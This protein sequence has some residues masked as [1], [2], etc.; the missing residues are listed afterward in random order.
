MQRQYV[1]SSIPIPTLWWI[2]CSVLSVVFQNV[3]W[4]KACYFREQDASSV[5][6]MFIYCHGISENMSILILRRTFSLSSFISYIVFCSQ[7]HFWKAMLFSLPQ[8]HVAPSGPF[9]FLQT[10]PKIF[11]RVDIFIWFY[12]CHV[13]IFVSS[14]SI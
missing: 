4:Y 14:S 5:T 7:S 12:F 6:H 3:V 1:R 8:H 10:L 11:H 9:L 2:L 13:V